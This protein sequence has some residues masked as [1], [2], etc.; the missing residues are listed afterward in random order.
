MPLTSSPDTPVPLRVVVGEVKKWVERLGE[1]WVEGQVVQLNRRAGSLHFLT[2]RDK[3]ADTSVSVTVSTRTLDAAGPL[4]D[5]ATVAALL[6]PAVFASNGRL[7]FDCHDLRPVG[8]GRLLAQL[9]QTKRLLRAEGLFDPALKQRLPFL[10]RRIG[11]IT[12]A[13]SAAERDVLTNVQDRWPAAVFEIRHTQVQGPSAA[14]QVIEAVAGLD[15]HPE[16]DVIV[17]A[18]GGGSFEDLLPFSDEG[19]VRA[20]FA[21][22][23]PVVSAI[24]HEVDTPLLD[25]VADLRASTPTDAAKRVVPDVAEQSRGVRQAR[26]RLRRAVAAL[27]AAL[28][29]QLDG[30]RARQ[31]MRDPSGVLD[32]HAE[33]LEATRHRLRRAVAA[34]VDARVR[35][36]DHLTLRL[37]SLSPQ[38]TL[39]RG[40]AI[41]VGP[42]T[43]TVTSVAQVTPG[44]RVTAFLADGELTADVASITKTR[45]TDVPDPRP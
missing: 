7:V 41:L 29:A 2:L 35:E 19:L 16:V 30:V 4:A 11:L 12:G 44:D 26:D 6:K 15:R 32:L 36:V 31:V 17:I 33:R 34:D 21:C 25:H 14:A 22:R 40:Y 24:G 20:V 8:I 27:H 39:A 5:G 13:G 45:R 10:P 3:L 18:R 23:T 37:R 38:R 43:T 42:A 28:Q 1:I 9:E